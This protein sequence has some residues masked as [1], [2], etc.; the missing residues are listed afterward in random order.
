MEIYITRH[1][2]THWNLEARIQGFLDSPLTEKGEEDARKLRDRLK[3]E[4]IEVAYTSDQNR[5]IETAKIIMGNDNLI[6]KRELRE[7]GVGLWQGMLYSDI[8]KNYPDEFYLYK[9]EPLKYVP[10]EGGEDYETFY[11]R[12]YK[13]TEDLKNAPY[14]KV[15]IVTHGLTYMMLLT[16]F[17]NNN[18]ED[19][20]RKK[21]PG[22]T[23]L[24]KINYEN[25]IYKIE[26]ENCTTHL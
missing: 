24:A 5:A 10:T 4:N 1:G 12:V 11:K 8:E 25:G 6:I 20:V 22:G 13:F 2:Q 7:I 19:V 3:D 16:I 21:L 9:N 26:Y 18:M 23:A 15:L 14:E 17:E